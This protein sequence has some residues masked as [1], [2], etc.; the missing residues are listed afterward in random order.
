MRLLILAAAILAM[1]GCALGQEQKKASVDQFQEV[2]FCQ[3][4]GDPSPFV[5]KRIRV[6]AIYSYMFEVSVLKPADCCA[7][8]NRTIWVD[9]KDEDDMDRDTKGLLHEFPKGMGVVLAT[10]EGTFE[11]GKAY[12]TGGHQFRLYID[13]V[14]RLEHKA[15][16][17]HH[18]PRWEPKCEP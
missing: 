8:S 15:K 10:F 9:F 7:D 18:R 1:L 4:A 3:L 14:V 17:L 11:G 13:R 6:R 16:A 5:G 12:G 2:T